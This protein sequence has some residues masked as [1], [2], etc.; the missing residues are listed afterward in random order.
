MLQPSKLR[1][2]GQNCPTIEVF[3]APLIVR[4]QELPWNL[5]KLTLGQMIIKLGPKYQAAVYVYCGN[6]NYQQPIY[7]KLGDNLA[8]EKP[9]SVTPPN[10]NV[11]AMV[12][13][14]EVDPK[15]NHP[16]K[17]NETDDHKED[18]SKDK[19][20]E[21]ESKDDAKEKTDQEKK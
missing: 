8:T 16:E 13:N 18:S 19:D 3:P 6:D 20:S 7:V 12:I 15:L 9:N 2:Y 21:K 5:G 4:T 14:P 17:A 10:K 11:K 1:A